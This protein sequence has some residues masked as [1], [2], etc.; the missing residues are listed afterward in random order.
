[1]LKILSLGALAVMISACAGIPPTGGSFVGG[2]DGG[3]GGGGT[4]IIVVPPGSP[5]SGGS[6]VVTHSKDDCKQGGWEA[7]G[8]RNQGQCVSAANG[9]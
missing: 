8:Y 1:M 7:L 6:G 4:T 9:N 3:G 2:G 5:G